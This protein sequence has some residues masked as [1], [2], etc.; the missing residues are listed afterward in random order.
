MPAGSRYWPAT[1]RGSSAA[2]RRRCS[3]CP[4][5]LT[6][7]AS[8]RPT[9]CTSATSTRRAGPA[10]GPA[11]AA[12][13]SPAESRLGWGSAQAVD[14][15]QLPVQT[16]VIKAVADHEPVGNPKAREVDVDADLTPSRS[17]QEG[18]QAQ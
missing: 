13:P 15:G 18:G 5:A 1:A 10:S 8:K 16:P 6:R 17:I 2:G 12:G 3:A 9:G 4:H 14:A 7:A 11:R